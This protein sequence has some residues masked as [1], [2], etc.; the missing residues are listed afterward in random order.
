MVK[1]GQNFLTSKNIAQKI[2][3]AAE[4]KKNDVVLEIGPGRGILTEELL[5]RA[6]RVVAVEKDPELFNFLNKKFETSILS[7]HLTLV[8]ADIRDFLHGQNRVLTTSGKNSVLTTYRVIANIPYYLT[9][10]LL[11]LLLPQ[12]LPLADKAGLCPPRIEK[13][14]LMLQK[15]V[16]KRIISGQNSVLT[17]FGKNRVLTKVPKTNLL[18]ISVWVYADPKIAFLVKK[19]N[20]MP[21]PKVDS[22]V[23]VF[24]R[25]EKDFFRQH[26]ISQKE[27]FEVVKAGFAHP[28]KLLKNNLKGLLDIGCRVRCGVKENAR[29][30]DLS[31]ENWACLTGSA[32]DIHREK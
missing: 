10:R 21:Q 9:G 27:F 11:R 26:K 1:L 32:Q 18:A 8:R 7:G 31:L 29:A 2:A 28:R 16:A 23:V 20:F 24:K 19:G 14:V 5:K 13:I 30:E 22:A 4:I 17:I 6:K 3:L 12:M 25:R 15:E